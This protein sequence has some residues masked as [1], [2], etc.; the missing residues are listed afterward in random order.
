MATVIKNESG[1][2]SRGSH[3]GDPK[4]PLPVYIGKT[5]DE[6]MQ[7]CYRYNEKN[8]GY[9]VLEQQRIYFSS[10][11]CEP[12]KVVCD[13]ESDRYTIM[14]DNEDALT[15][16][17]DQCVEAVRQLYKLLWPCPFSG[18]ECEECGEPLLGFECM[19]ETCPASPLY[20]DRNGD[21]GTHAEGEGATA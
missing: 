19:E 6:A 2:L 1:Y 12:V 17:Y 3:S 14:V 4:D 7:W 18:P 16:D 5:F 15:L 10:K 9:S 8:L 21:N 11:R 20:V 13:E